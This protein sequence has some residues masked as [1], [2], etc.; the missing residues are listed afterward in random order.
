MCDRG[1]QHLRRTWR[2]SKLTHSQQQCGR[3]CCLL[4]QC[5]APCAAAASKAAN[6][7][8]S[9]S[10]GSRCTACSMLYTACTTSAA[11]IA[12]WNCAARDKRRRRTMVSVSDK[13]HETVTPRARPPYWVRQIRALQRLPKRVPRRRLHTQLHKNAMGSQDS[14][15]HCVQR[16]GR[17]GCEGKNVERFKVLRASR[18]AAA[19]TE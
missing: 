5:D 13:R 2:L 9:V 7:S 1:A 11:C 12:L 17:C 19:K 8:S 10:F 4:L 15:E 14:R 3:C 16:V 6:T 18:D